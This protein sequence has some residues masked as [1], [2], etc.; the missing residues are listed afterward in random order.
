MGWPH[1]IGLAPLGWGGWPCRDRPLRLGGETGEK[2]DK[3]IAFMTDDK[4]SEERV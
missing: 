3:R 4:G 1:L 2:C